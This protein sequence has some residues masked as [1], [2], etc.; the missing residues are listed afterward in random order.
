MVEYKGSI[1]V[2]WGEKTK[3]ERENENP[4]N[5]NEN[6]TYN[7]WEVIIYLCIFVGLENEFKASH[8]LDKYSATELYIPTPEVNL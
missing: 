4:V 7:Q 3:L 1:P 8:M 2:P 5:K 6:N